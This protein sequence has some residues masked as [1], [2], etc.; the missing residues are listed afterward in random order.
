MV[1]RTSVIAITDTEKILRHMT[2]QIG[3]PVIPPVGER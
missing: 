3:V 2:T 1:G